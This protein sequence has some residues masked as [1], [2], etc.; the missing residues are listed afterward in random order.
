MC[1]EEWVFFNA[2][3]VLPCYVI[4]L[5]ESKKPRHGKLPPH[6]PPLAAGLLQ[7]QQDDDEDVSERE[8]ER[9]KKDKLLA[10]VS[11]LKQ[12]TVVHRST[13]RSLPS[14][15]QPPAFQCGDFRGSFQAT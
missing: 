1:G 9:L 6:P 10:R 15:A 7:Q 11:E 8:R 4:Q 13:N 2:A 12:F 3:Q 14:P 5:Y